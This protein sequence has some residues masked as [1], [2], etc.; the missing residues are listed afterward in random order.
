MIAHPETV[1]DFLRAF[2]KAASD[3][4][5]SFV[6]WRK[7][8]DALVDLGLTTAQ[9]TDIVLGLTYTDYCEGPL[10]AKKGGKSRLWVFA[11]PH[12]STHIY[13]KLKLV[14]VSGGPKPV[15]VSFH[16]KEHPLNFPLKKEE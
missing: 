7:N 4:E 13:I 6:G 16:E 8:W 1:K 11:V 12:D 14:K 9:R 3:S 5:I 15:C 2:K 10:K